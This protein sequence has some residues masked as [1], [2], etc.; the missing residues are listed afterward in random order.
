MSAAAV[1]AR[2]KLVSELRRLCLSLGAAKIEPRSLSRNE[3]KEDEQKP[4]KIK[5]P[6]TN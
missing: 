2:L 6:K 1:T 5:K 3:E 4:K